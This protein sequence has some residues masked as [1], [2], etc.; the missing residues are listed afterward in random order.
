ML[1]EIC[2]HHCAG[3]ES[4]ASRSI[5]TS[6]TMKLTRFSSHGA[7]AER[8]ADAASMTNLFLPGARTAASDDPVSNESLA[9]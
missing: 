2:G 6:R 1:Q 8:F 9:R 3:H 4:G 7:D 5:D